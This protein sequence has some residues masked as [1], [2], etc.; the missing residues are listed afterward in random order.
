VNAAPRRNTRG[1]SS[2]RSSQPSTVAAVN[3]AAGTSPR[4]ASIPGSARPEVQTRDSTVTE[5]DPSSDWSRDDQRWAAWMSAAQLGDK[6]AYEQLL[7][8][9]AA[10]IRQYLHVR[11]GPAEFID[12]IMQ[13]CLLSMHNGRHTYD[14]KRPFR[15]W[16]FAIVRH[17]SID[18]LRRRGKDISTAGPVDS[19]LPSNTGAVA[20]IVDASLILSQLSKDHRDIIVLTKYFGYSAEEVGTQLGISGAAVRVRLHRALRHTRRLFNT[21]DLEP[22]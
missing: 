10:T 20:T 19:D 7:T 21:E 3:E 14:A 15:A 9:V 13:E 1:I 2:Y 16:M 17:R 4:V 5:A 11:F 18:F 22:Q 12:D 8:E 6:Q